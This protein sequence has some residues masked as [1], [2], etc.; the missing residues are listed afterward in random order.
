MPDLENKVALITGAAS[1]MGAACATAL[2]RCGARVVLADLDADR[3]AQAAAGLDALF[4][5]GDV[6]DSAFCDRA[7][8]ATVDRHGRLD[9]LVNAAGIMV[10]KKAIDTDDDTYHRV[11]GVNLDGTFYMCRAALRQMKAQG[12]G[13]IVNFSSI[14]GLWAGANSAAYGAAKGGISVL[15]RALA[16][17]H[18]R[19]NIRVNAVL[20]GDVDT[21]L[22]RAGGRDEP[23][24]DED[25]LRMG[26]SIPLG[27]VARPEEIASVVAFLASDE[28]SYLTGILVP[29]DGGYSAQ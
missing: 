12:G 28:A 6:S 15:T 29:A 22:L 19:D 3:G 27:R 17:D 4:L 24:T 23:L 13:A 1:G 16:L 18:G 9:I 26:E 25:V 10:R 2:H 5:H 11:L 20:P 7:V 8:T 21:P 14:W